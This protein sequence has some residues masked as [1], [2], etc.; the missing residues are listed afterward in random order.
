MQPDALEAILSRLDRIIALLE[1]AGRAE[2]SPQPEAAP[3][4]PFAADTRDGLPVP[5]VATSEIGATPEID[6]GLADFLRARGI[7]IRTVPTRT[8][9]DDPLDSTAVFLGERY[10]ALRPVL[11]EI[12]RTMAQGK[13]WSHS[14]KGRPSEAISSSCQF[15]S[16]LHDLALLTSYT[17]HRSPRFVLH[18]TTS[19]APMAQ[20]FFS[21]GWLERYV[22]SCVHRVAGQL[23]TQ[24]AVLANAQVVLPNGRD[25]EFDLLVRVGETVF[26]CEAKSA[27]YQ[28]HAEKYTKLARMLGFPPE[29]AILV[30]AEAK[31]QNLSL[32]SRLWG[33]TVVDLDSLC[34]TLAAAFAA[35]APG[36]PRSEAAPDETPRFASPASGLA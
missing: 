18:A 35:A 3:D 12:K 8:P 10:A 29:R 32:L 21:G 15:C 28:E 23:G 27:T 19:S 6:P 22:R 36:A 31:V 13:S 1:S 9:A 25:F 14:L 33:L 26:W 16:T 34:A 24:A 7:S 17:Y 5:L 2:K 4:A 30:L 11:S 20:N